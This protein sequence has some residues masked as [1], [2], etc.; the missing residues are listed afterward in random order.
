VKKRLDKKHSE[1]VLEL[2]RK[3]TL[4]RNIGVPSARGYFSSS[5]IVDIHSE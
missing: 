1:I 2:I 3:R 5:P 4:P